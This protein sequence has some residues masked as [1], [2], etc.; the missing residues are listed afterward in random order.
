MKRRDLLKLFAITPIAA[1]LK[2]G[3]VTVPPVNEPTR[4]QHTGE[5]MLESTAVGRKAFIRTA[6]IETEVLQFRK[7]ETK[8]FEVPECKSMTFYAAD[9]NEGPIYFGAEKDPVADGLCLRPGR[10][11][12]AGEVPAAHLYAVGPQDALMIVTFMN[13]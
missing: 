4:V 10:Q 8:V 12:I 7:G 3:K 2:A 13:G 9:E 6:L 11:F 5:V 1:A